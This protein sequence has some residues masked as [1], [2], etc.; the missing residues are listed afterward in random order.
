MPQITSSRP[1]S[2]R[3]V[4]LLLLGLAALAPCA[5]LPRYLRAKN[6]LEWPQAHGVITSARLVPGQFKQIEGYRPEIQY[7]YQVGAT[8]YLSS[9]RSFSRPHLATQ[10]ASLS[11]LDAYQAGKTVTVFYDPK[12]PAFSVLEPGLA[13]DMTML[14]KMDLLLIAAFGAALLIALYKFREPAAR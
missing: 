4:L 10:A 1:F 3:G 2:S 9:R 5:A 14:Y 13:G 8:E 11:V 12:D 6:S 7:R